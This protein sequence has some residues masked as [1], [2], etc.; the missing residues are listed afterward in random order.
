MTL[1]PLD[2]GQH[3]LEAGITGLARQ[4]EW[5]AVVSVEAPGADGDE[6]GFVALPDDRLL[7][8]DP[9]SG[10]DLAPFAAALEGSI[11]RPYRAFAVR[12]PEIWVVGASAVEAVKLEPDPGGRDLELISDGSSLT[13]SVDGLPADPSRAD[14]LARIA[15]ERETGAY[16]AAAH[17]LDGELWELLV[18]AL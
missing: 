18:L 8:D 1:G 15:S 5:D 16:S 2:P 6:A 4:R 7:A 17:R 3:W 9:A 10:I 14:A 11:D 12:R 13:L